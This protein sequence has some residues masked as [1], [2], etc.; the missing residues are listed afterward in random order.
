MVITP[1]RRS[2]VLVVALLLL[3]LITPPGPV[4]SPVPDL[5]A[6]ERF[7]KA[8]MDAHRIPGL[9]LA[10]ARGDEIVAVQGYGLSGEGA[11]ITPQTQFLVASLSKSFTATAVL[12]LV[13][14]GR[15]A[16]DQ[17]VQNYLPAFTLAD[18]DVAAR[19]TVRQ[20]LNQTSGLGDMGFTAGLG[21]EQGSLEERVASLRDARPVSA[22]GTQFH[23]SDLNYQVLARLVEV[24]SGQPFDEYLRAN[25]FAPLGMGDT[26][27]A[28]TVDEATR[29]AGNLA[30]GHLVVYGVPVPARELSGFLGGSSGVVSTAA[31][32]ARYLAMQGDGAY[33]G[34]RLLTPESLALMQTPPPDVPSSHYGMGWLAGGVGGVRTVEHNGVLSTFY[35]E[36]V[37]LPES[38]Y[39]FVL[40]YDVYALSSAALAFPQLKAGLVA[41]LTGQEPPAPGLSVPLLGG[42][43][44]ALSAIGVLLALRS[45]LSLPRWAAA[46]V[47]TPPWRLALGICAAGA[48]GLLLLALPWLLAQGSGRYFGY[49]MLA[50]AMPDLMIWLGA[51]GLLGALNAVLRLALLA[52]RARGGTQATAAFER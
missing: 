21:R 44:A 25:L 12:Q 39:G 42:V 47:R 34:R 4:A 5:G 27:S 23:Y 1:Y 7:V 50:R 30:R 38:G 29:R 14:A 3:R 6:V 20:L 17:P 33:G 16:L 45:L 31:D 11:P 37:L 24:V 10:I 48:P 13:E 8:Q 32:L 51:C 15:I 2:E 43:L 49:V 52:R 19:I 26:F 41:L 36:A 9:A 46:I 28:V 22:P 40:L 35:A 18:P